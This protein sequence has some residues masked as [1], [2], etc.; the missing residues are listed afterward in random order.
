M[1]RS[2]SAPD[3]SSRTP[4]G[5]PTST[6]IVGEVPGTVPMADAAYTEADHEFRENDDYA[7]AKYDITLRWLGRPSTSTCRL[8]NVGCGAG[9]FNRLANEAGYDVE[10]CEPDPVA[11]RRAIDVGPP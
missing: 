8:V 2:S 3:T 10:A 1:K 11:R 7:R 9:L 5:F 4:Q 6:C